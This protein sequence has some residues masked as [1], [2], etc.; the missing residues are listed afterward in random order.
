[1]RVKIQ[2]YIELTKEQ[3]DELSVLMEVKMPNHKVT[4]CGVVVEKMWLTK[5]EK[6]KI[7][8]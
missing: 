4:Y 6:K 5:K 8:S 7:T 2:G 3:I 1:M